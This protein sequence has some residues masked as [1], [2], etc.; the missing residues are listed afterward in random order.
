[1]ETMTSIDF[2]AWLKNQKKKP[3]KYRNII[4]YVGNIRFDSKAEAR[5]YEQ[6]LLLQRAGKISELKLQP[7]FEL[8]AKFKDINGNT[9]RAIT[10]LADFQYN[11]NG[12]LV[13]EDVKG[14]ETKEFLIKK[15]MFLQKYPNVDF[16]LIKGR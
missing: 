13:I 3:S 14:K 15:K 1:M 2:Q 4:T 7:S 6:L 16:R 9:Q 8:Q 10:Y 11:E 5:R 12:R